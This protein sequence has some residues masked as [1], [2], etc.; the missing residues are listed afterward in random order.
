MSLKVK[1]C[2]FYLIFWYYQLVRFWDAK[3]NHRW[4]LSWT[5]Y[6]SSKLNSNAVESLIASSFWKKIDFQKTAKSVCIPLFGMRVSQK[7]M[8]PG[9][10]FQCRCFVPEEP[11][12]LN[13]LF[14]EAK[15]KF[16]Q[17]KLFLFFIKEVCIVFFAFF[18]KNLK[19]W[20]KI[21]KNIR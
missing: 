19:I 17:L 11:E 18:L 9:N 13:K 2:D 5:S 4:L 20:S 21:Q 15:T 6:S 3:E 14:L 10:C 16:I 7:K 12:E 8:F 1:S